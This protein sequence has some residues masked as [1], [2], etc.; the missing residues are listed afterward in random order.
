MI[1]K[2]DISRVYPLSCAESYFLAWM[3][4]CGIPCGLLYNTSFVPLGK[5][6]SDFLAHGAK[7]ESYNEI[8]RVMAL[9]KRYGIIEY[10][11]HRYFDKNIDESIRCG[12]LVLAEVNH[13]FF[14]RHLLR[15]WRDDHYICITDVDSSGN[16]LYVN[17]FPL[18]EGKL[19]QAE[20]E[21]Y[22]GGK[23]IEYKLTGTADEI[24]K[25]DEAAQFVEIIFNETD[26][27]VLHGLDDM[28]K[29]RDCIG[30]M[31][32]TRRRLQSWLRY[33]SSERRFCYDVPIE[34]VFDEYFHCLDMLFVRLEAASLR[35]KPIKQGIEDKINEIAT[36][37]KR[38]SQL[39]R[40]RRTEEEY[41]R[42]F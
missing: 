32:M 21:T 12:N 38:L 9:A 4:A 27:S 24:C 18:S 6:L 30:I 14:E 39:I 26:V 16:Y 40:T 17:Q 25:K 42:D 19:T 22:F 35:D 11:V 36:Y 13:S 31:R 2:E 29:L 1:T 3:K 8:E 5:V 28:R 37:E 20:I 23:V 34:S 7:Y 33:V 10:T 15:P 41:E